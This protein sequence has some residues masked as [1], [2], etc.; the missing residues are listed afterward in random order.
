VKF[1]SSHG[2]HPEHVLDEKKQE[3]PPLRFFL[4]TGHR[5]GSI[6]KLGMPGRDSRPGEVLL[7]EMGFGPGVH[8][9]PRHILPS[10]PETVAFDKAL[11]RDLAPEGYV[12]TDNPV[13]TAF[14]KEAHRPPTEEAVHEHRGLVRF[15]HVLEDPSQQP[16]FASEVGW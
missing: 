6:Q 12:V 8:K 13:A 3:E 1:Q 10:Q 5:E 4:L 9:K 15:G 2:T 14:G 16:A 11:P 7:D